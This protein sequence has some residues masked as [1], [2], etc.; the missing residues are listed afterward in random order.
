MI[1][2]ID[3]EATLSALKQYQSSLPKSRSKSKLVIANCMDV[4]DKLESVSVRQSQGAYWIPITRSVNECS[5][6]GAKVISDDSGVWKYCPS[7][8]R[9][10]VW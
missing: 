4:V 7:C 1:S 2:Y 3:K 9:I 10:M 6:C 8:G 5:S